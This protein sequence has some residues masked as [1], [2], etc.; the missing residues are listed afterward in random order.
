MTLEWRLSGRWV[1]DG[2][3]EADIRVSEGAGRIN[4]GYMGVRDN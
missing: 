3:V 2:G 4:E 1:S